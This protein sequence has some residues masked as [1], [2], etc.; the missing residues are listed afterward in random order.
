M[1]KATHRCWY[2]IHL[3]PTEYLY[4]ESKLWSIQRLA[5][6]S[7]RYCVLHCLNSKISDKC[8]QHFWKCL[9]HFFYVHIVCWISQQRCHFFILIP[10]PSLFI[11]SFKKPDTEQRTLPKITEGRNRQRS[12]CLKDPWSTIVLPARLPGWCTSECRM[13]SSSQQSTPTCWNSHNCKVMRKVRAATGKKQGLPLQKRNTSSAKSY[14]LNIS[15][16]NI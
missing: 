3:R 9:F 1:C 6:L 2:F 13:A 5:Q 15:S 4:S 14:F 11:Q 10:H 16:Q 8:R 7:L 12:V